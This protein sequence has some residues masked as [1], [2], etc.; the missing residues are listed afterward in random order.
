[1]QQKQ[2]VPANFSGNVNLETGRSQLKGFH[3]P[4]TRQQKARLVKRRK[5][6]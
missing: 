6:R 4:D 3:I 1:M 2:D 5:R